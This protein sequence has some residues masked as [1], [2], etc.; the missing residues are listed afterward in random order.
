LAQW[1]TGKTTNT[2]FE[3]LTRNADQVFHFYEGPRAEG[4]IVS[5]AHPRTQE[6]QTTLE[7]GLD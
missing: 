5:N 1:D 2:F 7:A 6:S 4:R 3:Y